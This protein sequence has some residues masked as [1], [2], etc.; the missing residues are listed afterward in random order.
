MTS[1]AASADDAL[2]GVDPAWRAGTDAFDYST[3]A[4]TIP[5]M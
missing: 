2:I 4:S 3:T 1:L 5:R